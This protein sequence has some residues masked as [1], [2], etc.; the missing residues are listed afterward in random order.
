MKRKGLVLCVLLTLCLSGAA[1]ADT[2]SYYTTGT[3][4]SGT[5]T[6][7][8]FS[9]AGS[10]SS[11]LTSPNLA[12]SSVVG[13]FANINLGTFSC[14]AACATGGSGTD[15]FKLNVFQT[16]PPSGGDA[17]VVGT[18]SGQISFNTN[19]NT[20]QLDFGSANFVIAGVNYTSLV[21]ALAGYSYAVDTGLNIALNGPGGTTTI[22]GIVYAP[23]PA[24]MLLFGTG[25]I[26]VAGVIRK[27]ALGR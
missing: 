4:G 5:F 3:F 21:P 8:T 16:A 9:G 22:Q 25:L 19:T 12:G 13:P 6:G 10:V 24:S 26:G 15:S 11:P 18:I 27:K 23:E 2:V 17:S 20:L 7:L 1:L 14:T